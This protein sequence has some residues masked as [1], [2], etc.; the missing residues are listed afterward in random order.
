VNLLADA[1]VFPE[2]LT[3]QDVSGELARWG[4]TW[5]GDPDAYARVT[6][7]LAAL[8]ERVAQPGASGRAADHIVTWLHQHRE[9]GPTTVIADHSTAAYRGPHEPGIRQ[10][11]AE[12][13]GSHSR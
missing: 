9:E 13:P 4:A 10:E 11:P 2:Y 8:R 12:G 3:W 7:D 1:E 5:L 6:A